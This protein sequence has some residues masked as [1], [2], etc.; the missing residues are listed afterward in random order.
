MNDIMVDTCGRPPSGSTTC[1]SQQLQTLTV[2][3]T[4]QNQ[5]IQSTIQSTVRV[6]VRIRPLNMTEQNQNCK[7]LIYSIPESSNSLL[8]QRHSTQEMNTHHDDEEHREQIKLNEQLHSLHRHE[9]VLSGDKMQLMKNNEDDTETQSTAGS[10]QS[11]VSLNSTGS[12]TKASSDFSLRR[13]VANALQI[14][15]DIRDSVKKDEYIDSDF[16]E[17]KSHEYKGKYSSCNKKIKPL[18]KRIVVEAARYH[19]QFEFDAV[20]SAT[21][22]QD[23]V[24]RNAVGDIVEKV[25]LGYNATI[26]AYG[27]TGSG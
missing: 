26:I 25:F 21:T 4:E 18:S 14:D 23:E 15:E 17:G 24:Y 5:P 10:M 20:L 13:Q 1:R 3:S 16:V 7:C 8:P 19:R 6:V 11:T 22:T 2:K 27:Q 9:T 12:H